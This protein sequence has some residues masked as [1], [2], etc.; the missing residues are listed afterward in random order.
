MQRPRRRAPMVARHAATV[1]L[2]ALVPVLTADAAEATAGLAARRALRR[3]S[4][5]AKLGGFAGDEVPEG[6]PEDADVARYG[7]DGCVSAWR[8]AA[9]HCVIRTDCSGLTESM[10]NFSISF[11]CVDATGE[12]SRHSFGAGAFGGQ[13]TF[14]TLISCS[15]CAGVDDDVPA[16]PSAGA[17]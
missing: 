11:L 2:V 4:A 16:A 7:P 17:I 10:A 14:D 13:D 15:S 8:S 1:L 12:S 5:S 9:S 6:P 3:S